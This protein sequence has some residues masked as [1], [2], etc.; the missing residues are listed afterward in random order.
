MQV[1]DPLALRAMAHPLRLDLIEMLGTVG[2]ST[3]AEC[4]RR[5]G[6]TQASCSYH[7]RLLAK[8]GFVEL[9]DARGDARD[10][11]WR[12]TDVEQQWSSDG[13]ASDQFERVFVQREADRIL[14][15]KAARKHEPEG[16]RSADFVG[17]A[18]LPLT[19]TELKDV[20]AQLQRVLEPYIARLTDRTDWPE[21]YRFVRILLAGTPSAA[22]PT[23]DDP[24]DDDQTE[25]TDR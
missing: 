2:P 1:T 15:W 25:E 4:A 7:L 23:D 3:A 14:G 6:S 22:S 20:R 21:G 17:G 18:S 16:W 19:A 10:R 11:P 9:A 24:S 12:L 13:A 5:L 8:Y